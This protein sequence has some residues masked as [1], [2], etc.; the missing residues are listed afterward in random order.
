[1]NFDYNP[2]QE[3]YNNQLSELG[4]SLNENLCVINPNYKWAITGTPSENGIDNIMGILQFLTKKNYIESF[5]L[6]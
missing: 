2:Q 3:K 6:V 4:I 5:S 1:M